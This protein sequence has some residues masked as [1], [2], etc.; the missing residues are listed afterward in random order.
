V[1]GFLK[2]IFT[3]T[4]STTDNNRNKSPRV[5]N[6]VPISNQELSDIE[7]S[8]LRL[9]EGRRADDPS[10]LGWW[11]AFNNVNRDQIISK[12][13]KNNYLTLANYKF[14]I[15]KETIPV[16]KAFLK[17]H[18]LSVKGK[19]GD[20]V[21]RIIENV[22]EVDCSSHFT[23]PYWAYTEKAIE[24]L[25]AEEI[26]A[27]EEYNANIELIRK[28]SYDELK[29]KLYPNRNEHW[30]TEDTFFETINFIMKHAFEEF[31]LSEDVRKNLASFIAERSVDYSSRGYLICEKDISNYL[32]TLN[33][34]LKSL[35]LPISLEDYANDNEIKSQNEIYDTYIQFI[36]N[37]ARSVAELKNYDRLGYRKIKID[38]VGCVECKIKKNDMIY[39]IN[40]V[41]LLPLRWGCRCTYSILTN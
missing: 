2:R 20:L 14:S 28:G 39:G 6:E 16:L 37:R 27:E 10:L 12:I 19:K 26:K 33:I 11:C 4:A 34:E 38:T 1:N 25:H 3:L 22:S 29:R 32:G 41:P 21:N 17:E 13:Q 5:L 40:N 36:I 7:I 31:G 8:F 35:R 23:R 24:L 30:G 9:L 15:K 18:E